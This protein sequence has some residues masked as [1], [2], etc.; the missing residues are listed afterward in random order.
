MSSRTV[1]GREDFSRNNECS[2]IGSKVLEEVAETIERK[3]ASSRDFMEPKSNNAK[4]NRED[5]KTS[6]LDRFP[7]DSV[8][9]CDRHPIAGDETCA[10]E[11]EVSYAI[12]IES[13]A[14]NVSCRSKSYF[15]YMFAPPE[16]PIA[17]RMMDVFRPSPYY[18][19]L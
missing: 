18:E 10:R 6:K 1:T 17:P 12:V 2:G 14:V 15:K 9:G 8:D 7:P 4:Q 13:S 11:D 19:L 3:E 5:N 16:Y